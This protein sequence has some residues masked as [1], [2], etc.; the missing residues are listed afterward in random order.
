MI[1]P[2]YKEEID[3]SQLSLN[4]EIALQKQVHTYNEEQVKDMYE[5]HKE[6]K[7]NYQWYKWWCAIM[8][9][10][11]KLVTARHEVENFIKLNTSKGGIHEN[12]WFV[13]IG[14]NPLQKNIKLVVSVIDELMSNEW[15]KKA[16]WVYENHTEHGEKLHIM[17][18]IQ[19]HEKFVK[20][21]LIQK[22][23]RSKGLGKIVEMNQGRSSTYVSVLPYKEYHED[24]INL[25][26]TDKKTDL[27]DKDETFRKNNNLKIKYS[28]IV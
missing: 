26:K 14:I 13:T 28:T 24:Y 10:S 1:F 8:V 16:D 7:D 17:C 21:V 3:Y 22:I 15:I 2:D 19:T 9:E 23:C 18:K 11:L 12:T 6:M 5:I 20:S 27:L 25:I 4:S